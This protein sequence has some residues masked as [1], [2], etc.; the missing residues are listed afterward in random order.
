[1]E[2]KCLGSLGTD[3][4]GGGSLDGLNVDAGD[5]VGVVDGLGGEN[6]GEDGER[7]GDVLGSADQL[8]V[9]ATATVLEGHLVGVGVQADDAGG[10][11]ASVKTSKTSADDATSNNVVSNE[12]DA[13]GGSDHGDEEEGDSEDS[14]HFSLKPE[15]GKEII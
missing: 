3:D 14:G 6:I 2:G 8:Q 10:E 1:L 11:D 7:V 13:H 15:M 12:S 4:S 5:G 9:V